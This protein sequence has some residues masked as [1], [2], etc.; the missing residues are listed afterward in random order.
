MIPLQQ[1]GELRGVC[2]WHKPNSPWLSGE[3]HRS[4]HCISAKLQMQPAAGKAC[5]VSSQDHTIVPTLPPSWGH[6]TRLG[7]F[8]TAEIYCLQFHVI[9][10]MSFPWVLISQ[11][12]TDHLCTF[13]LVLEVRNLSLMALKGHHFFQQESGSLLCSHLSLIMAHANFFTFIQYILTSVYTHMCLCTQNCSQNPVLL[14]AGACGHAH[15]LEQT[16][17][18]FATGDRSSQLLPLKLINIIKIPAHVFLPCLLYCFYSNFPLCFCL[19][20]CWMA[21]LSLCLV[22]L[23]TVPWYQPTEISPLPQ[24][25]PGLSG[26]RWKREAGLSKTHSI[27]MT[28]TAKA[29]WWAQD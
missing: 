17:D 26:Q 25:L 12:S 18:V 14:S 2:K 16:G 3:C 27:P 10:T 21:L 13:F 19:Q 15:L 11:V 23:F 7:S 9:S 29:V 20:C 4:W 1:I 8:S 24:L 22:L 6:P 28:T 5:S